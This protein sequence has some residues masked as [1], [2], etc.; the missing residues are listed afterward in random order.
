MHPR[1]QVPVGPGYQVP[2]AALIRSEA[3]VA[4]AAVGLITTA[5]QAAAIV[6]NGQADLV[7]LGREMIRTPHWALL[8]SAERGT[9]TP[10]PRPYER[11]RPYYSAT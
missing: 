8:A 2:F 10:G 1:A 3:R 7:L 6:E 11:A 9:P 5:R 4:T